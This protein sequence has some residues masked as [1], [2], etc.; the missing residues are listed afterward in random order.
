M[1]GYDDAVNWD[2]ALEYHTLDGASYLTNV[3]GVTLK[4]G[5]M[6]YSSGWT[7]YLPGRP[8]LSISFTPD[9]TSQQFEYDDR[10]LV[11]H[12]AGKIGIKW[13][14]GG[15][16]PNGA[17]MK[18]SIDG[19]LADAQRDFCAF[20]IVWDEHYDVPPA[21][22]TRPPREVP[23]DFAP[24][25]PA[26]NGPMVYSAKWNGVSGAADKLAAGNALNDVPGV[27]YNPSSGV[28]T[29]YG[30]DF[31][32]VLVMYEMEPNYVGDFSFIRAG[33]SEGRLNSLESN[34]PNSVKKCYMWIEFDISV[35]GAS[36]FLLLPPDGM[37]VYCCIT[38]YPGKY[39]DR[40]RD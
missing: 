33:R 17:S 32:Y 31:G 27:T 19:G 6:Y 4:A 13:L 23:D 9:V 8:S 7:R 25:K 40:L 26:D 1:L 16:F 35:S 37:P 14:A 12:T 2:G 24:A 39:D 5:I 29:N 15:V 28:V 20:K 3:S 18:M 21:L 36:D 11:D 34:G 22:L 38:F 30:G 10:F